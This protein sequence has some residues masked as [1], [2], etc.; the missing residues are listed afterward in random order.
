MYVLCSTLLSLPSHTVVRNLLAWLQRRQ[1]RLDMDA[2]V[3]ALIAL[4]FSAFGALNVVLNCI[5][6]RNVMYATNSALAEDCMELLSRLENSVIQLER[7]GRDEAA[8]YRS[9]LH[10]LRIR[11][12]R[13]FAWTE[14]TFRPLKRTDKLKRLNADLELL[15]DNIQPVSSR[16]NLDI[17]GM[18]EEMEL[19]AMVA[20]AGQER[21]GGRVTSFEQNFLEVGRLHA[22]I[23]YVTWVNQYVIEVT[24]ALAYAGYLTLLGLYLVDVNHRIAYVTYS[25]WVSQYMA[26]V[27]RVL[28]YAGYLAWLNQYLIDVTRRVAYVT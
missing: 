13:L 4:G 22:R 8:S 5:S 18:Q 25:T 16:I 10:P 19:D 9:R 20:I 12:E 27:T 11:A 2:T 26:R 23:C 15:V 3:I 28:A 21:Y 1:F 6:G 7:D 14:V 24:R 17:D